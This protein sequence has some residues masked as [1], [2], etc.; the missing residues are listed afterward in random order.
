M[1]LRKNLNNMIDTRRKGVFDPFTDLLFNALLGFTF[2]FLLAIM[3]MNPIA[4]S[5]IINPKAEYIITVNWPDDSLDDIDTWVEDP[6]GNIVWFRNREAGL[7]HLDRDDRGLSNDKI[8]I[9]GEDV[10]NKLNQEIVTI[11]GKVPGEFIVNLHYYETDSNKPVT[12]GV[13]VAKINPKMEIIYYGESTL[14]EK[15]DEETAI[16]FIVNQDGSVDRFSKVNR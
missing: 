14:R 7:V 5:G 3:Y 10:F 9:A 16:R 1:G 6:L 2:M 15:G 4:K 12:V 8:E 11:R 13:E